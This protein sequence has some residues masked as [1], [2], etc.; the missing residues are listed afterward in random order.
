M[1]RVILI[2]TVAA[3]AGCTNFH[4]VEE[5]KVYRSAQPDIDDL[6]QWID[7]YGL[8]SVVRLR[9]GGP[10]DDDY[11][12]SY[13]PTV[14][15]SIAFYHIPMSSSRF[16]KKKE[17]VRLCEVFETA[18]YPILIHCKAGADRTGLASA[19][20]ILYRGGG[21]DAARDQLDFIPYWHTGLFGTGDLDKVLDMYEPWRGTMDFCQWVREVYERP[22][23]DDLP[24]G[25]IEEQRVLAAQYV[26]EH[27]SPSSR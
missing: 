9:G 14:E 24:D 23:D 10:E 15:K 7:Q 12:E 22:E 16:P 4:V 17:L 1:S 27:S 26:R 25:Y 21:M 11:E 18:E 19:S 13:R 8:R 3:L 2:L 20:Y 6:R 5:G